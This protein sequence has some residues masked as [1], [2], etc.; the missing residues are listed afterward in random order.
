MAGI[1]FND[2]FL[3]NA[4][5]SDEQKSMLAEINL[6]FENHKMAKYRGQEAIDLAIE[7]LETC[8]KSMK[9]Y[10][11]YKNSKTQKLTP[12]ESLE[13]RCEIVDSN[14]TAVVNKGGVPDENDFIATTHIKEKW[15]QHKPSLE[16]VRNHHRKYC[17]RKKA[18]KECQACIWFEEK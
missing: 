16:D 3:D 5:L 14:I 13:L 1:R 6:S 17:A 15:Q 2:Y 8:K 18:N 4:F 10:E 12:E 11:E 9:E 7:F